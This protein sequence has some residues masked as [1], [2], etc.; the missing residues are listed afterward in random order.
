[1]T[2][3]D[4]AYI[5]HDYEQK[6]RTSRMASE[7]NKIHFY[8]YLVNFGMIYLYEHLKCLIKSQKLIELNYNYGHMAKIM[9]KTL[10]Y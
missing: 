1:M 7:V 5:G 10:K 8:K 4:Y 9:R 3:C 6:L 2:P